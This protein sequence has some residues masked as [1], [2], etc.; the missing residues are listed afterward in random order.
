MPVYNTLFEKGKAYI[1]SQNWVKAFEIF[2]DIRT[3][4]SCK[5]NQYISCLQLFNIYELTGNPDEGLQY[6]EESYLYDSDRV[7]GIYRLIV[8]YNVKGKYD[9]AFHHYQRIQEYYEQRYRNDTIS[10]RLAFDKSIY[11]FFLPYQ[12]IIASE[13]TRNHSTGLKMYDMIFRQK[14]Q[15][16]DSWYINNLIYNFQFFLLNTPKPKEFVDLFIGYINF[17]HESNIT[18]DITMIK[19]YI[20]ELDPIRMNEIHVLV[21]QCK[22]S[23]KILFYCGWAAIPWNHTVMETVGVGGSETCVAKLAKQFPCEYEIYVSGGVKEETNNNVTYVEFKDLERLVRTN[24]FYAIVISRYIGFLDDYPYFSSYKL[25]MWIHDLCFVTFKWV[26]HAYPP[27]VLQK[28][29]SR[30]DTV[31][32]LTEWHRTHFQG[33]YPILSDKII[34]IPNGITSST[35]NTNP[36]KKNNRFIFTS[37]PERGYAKLFELWPEITKRIPDAELKLA[38]YTGFPRD[39]YENEQMTWIE[40]QPNIE[41]MGCLKPSDLYS[42]M[43]SAEYWLYPTDFCETFCITAL[44]ML[45]NK[46]LCLYYPVAALQNTLG[47]YGIKVAIGSEIE[48]LMNLVGDNETKQHMMENGLTYARTFDWSNVVTKWVTMLES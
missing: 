45:H 27:D 4:E 46:V 12:V 22:K 38:T 1:D 33:L 43:G 21:E 5:Q 17:L 44:E 41:F 11:D 26:G 40:Q 24:D 42:L 37:C 48:A 14:Y 31:V 16:V 10:D 7:E 6:L 2:H 39:D 29:I 9:L 28:W 3:M 32:C 18:V 34:I 47:D 19:Q 23:K 15:G 13:R 25:I 36:V 20:R 35:F 8:H 30:I